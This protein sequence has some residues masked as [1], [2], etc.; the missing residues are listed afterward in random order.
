M[1]EYEK[2]NYEL[3][4]KVKMDW[5]TRCLESYHTHT[6]TCVKSVHIHSSF[7]DVEIKTSHVSSHS[8]L[9]IPEHVSIVCVDI[10][11]ALTTGRALFI[12]LAL[13]LALLLSLWCS[14]QSTNP[15][16]S[17]AS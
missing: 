8:G 16:R 15:S 4:D 17:T 3:P 14:A 11:A 7:F 12:F 5:T 1:R 2:S 6:H 9:I 13:A 10:H